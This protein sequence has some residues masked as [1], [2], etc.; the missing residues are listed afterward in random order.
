[1][2]SQKKLEK[3]SNQDLEE[4][5]KSNLLK[6]ENLRNIIKNFDKDLKKIAELSDEALKL[7]REFKTFHSNDFKIEYD[8]ESKFFGKNEGKIDFYF[9]SKS[10][11]NLYFST[12][13][14]AIK[15]ISEI[16]T[17]EKKFF[18][19]GSRLAEQGS[20]W[21]D[22]LSSGFMYDDYVSEPIGKTNQIYFSGDVIVKGGNKYKAYTERMG[23]INQRC[24]VETFDRTPIP[25]K[26]LYEEYLGIYERRNRKIEL[27]K[28]SRTREKTK[29][30]NVGYVYVLSNESLPPNTYKIGSTYGLPEERA[31]ELTGT[32]HLTPFKVV[33]KIK[34]QSAEYYEKSI[35]KILKDYRVKEGREFFKLDLKK[36]KDCFKQVSELSDKGE[37][38]LTSSDVKKRIKI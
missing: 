38:K 7:G 35:H 4:E 11:E 19:F 21:G 23:E 3:L 17:L 2:I 16:L 6:I 13:E 37:K 1:M 25:R 12:Y 34:V 5:R 30:E 14:K 15:K 22:T 28:R 8:E 32:G 33:A 18:F 10:K 29:S 26:K 24:M 9:E 20:V 36:I 31:E 27:I